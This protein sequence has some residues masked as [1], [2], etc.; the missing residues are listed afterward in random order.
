MP[1]AIAT[2][3][4]APLELPGRLTRWRVGWLWYAVALFLPLA[5]TV[6]A[7]AVHSLAGGSGPDV[8][9]WQGVLGASDG[10]FIVRLLSLLLIFTLGFDGLGEE[11]GW[12][13]FALPKLQARHTALW[14]SLILGLLWSLWHVPYALTAGSFMS[15]TPMSW[16]FLEIVASAIIYT[17]LFNNTRGSVLL[18]ILLH[19]AGN[20]TANLV[21]ILPP[22]REL[23]LEA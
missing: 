23:A 13:G 4:R 11:L 18:A 19:A 14:A 16:Y 8:S 22:G 6:V 2:R 17:W 1:Q 20:T 7:I 3:V 21:P 5:I 15:A 12:R 10:P 9:R